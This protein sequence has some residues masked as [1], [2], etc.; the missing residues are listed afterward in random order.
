MTTL[1][2]T[3]FP[4]EPAWRD[5]D[6]AIF[7]AS[8]VLHH[9]DSAARVHVVGDLCPST[10]PVLASMLDGLIDD[11]IA[12]IIVDMSD[13]RMCT[14]HGVDVLDHARERLS[15]QGGSLSVEHANGVVRKVL[16]LAEDDPEAGG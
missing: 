3:P 8:A 4:S 13:L 12:G 14:S 15:E 9:R 11:G 5:V 10:A 7:A 1:S 2:T 16:D 6:G